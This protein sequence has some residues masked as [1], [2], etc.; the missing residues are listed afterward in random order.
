MERLYCEQFA[1]NLPSCST[2][3]FLDSDRSDVL[4]TVRLQEI[5]IVAQIPTVSVITTPTFM[6]DRR[7]SGKSREL[8]VDLIWNTD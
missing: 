8:C 2:I 3:P 6:Y 4:S 7:I 5:S 1:R